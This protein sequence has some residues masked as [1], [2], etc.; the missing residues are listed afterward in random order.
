MFISEMTIYASNMTTS[1]NPNSH[2][3]KVERP[4]YEQ[5]QLNDELRYCQATDA[6]DRGHNI[7]TNIKSIETK[8][9]FFSIF[10]IFSWLPKYNFKNDL[11][12]DLMSGCTVAIMH[13]PQGLGYAML[14]NV[15]PI[16][17][18]YTAF[19]PVLIYFLFGT[20]KH[21][22]MGTF[23]VVSMLVGK[24]V[25]RLTSV[26]TGNSTIIENTSNLT[27]TDISVESLISVSPITV[28]VAITFV[29]GLIQ[30]TMYILRLG[31]LS[32]LLSESLVS[33]FTTG[34]GIHVIASQAKDLFGIHLT[35][36]TSYYRVILV[37][38]K[39]NF[40]ST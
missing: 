40:H 25:Q 27:S 20:S 11:M 31:V 12:G 8:R 35:P 14:A 30:V 37:N 6:N 33:G 3:L 9:I 15:P 1:P 19:F 22:S 21:N 5:E 39:L 26:N 7:W 10:P 16:A 23:A 2:M 36:V 34:A 28:A 29:V 18:I 13:I 17:G 4:Y 32:S 24:T 38:F